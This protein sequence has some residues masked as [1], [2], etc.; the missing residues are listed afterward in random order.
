VVIGRKHTGHV[1]PEDV[2]WFAS[3]SASNIVNCICDPDELQSQVAAVAGKRLPQP[4]YGETLA[5]RPPDQNIRRIYLTARDHFWEERHVA[6]IG[7]VREAVVQNRARKWVDL[8]ECNRSPAKRLPSYGS[9]LDARADAEIT[10][11]H[12]AASI[13]LRRDGSCGCS[14]WAGAGAVN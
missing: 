5:R 2:R 10:D 1:F 12:S 14:A 4:S 11:R 7:N 8:S 9:R 13:R 3:I 6:K